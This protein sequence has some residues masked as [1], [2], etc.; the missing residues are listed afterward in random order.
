MTGA[1]LS[2]NTGFADWKVVQTIGT[3]NDGLPLNTSS[4][5]VVLTGTL[6]LAV[7]LPGFEA[8]AWVNP[9]GG[10]A[11]VGQLASDGHFSNGGSIVCPDPTHCG[12]TAGFYSYSLIVPSEGGGSLALSGFTGDNGVRSLTI[13]QDASV[14]YST[15]PVITQ[16]STTATGTIN[17]GMGGNVV[18]TA[19]V[20]NL[21]GP[22]RNPS[23]FIASGSATTLPLSVPEVPNTS[24]IGL[25]II[26]LIALRSRQANS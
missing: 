11:W 9:F 7:N 15:A 23:G 16:A 6:P 24:L 8:F 25:G 26:T 12:A 3:S 13:M 20:E 18:I 10:A 14:L 4:S 2:L 5:A 19:L 22:G 1:N 17:F 21:D